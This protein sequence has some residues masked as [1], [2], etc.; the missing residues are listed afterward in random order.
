MKYKWL[1]VIPAL[2]ACSTAWFVIFHS[3][4]KK[5]DVVSPP[6]EIPSDWQA[7]DATSFT[8][9][10]PPGW[11][12]NRLQGIDSYVGEFVGDNMKLHFDYGMYSNPLAYENDPNY[13][14]T[15]E[16]IDN[17][18][19]KIVRPKAGLNGTT[20]IYFADLGDNRT[21]LEMSGEDLT[22]EQQETTL[23]IFR[24]LKFSK[25]NINNR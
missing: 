18:D 5:T 19:A 12:F 22:V 21:S 11:Q 13:I 2:I 7:I 25:E 10:L 23:R 8:L 20:G 17:Q 15:H 4:S 3:S 6:I 1:A 14:I 16:T 9:S 24:T